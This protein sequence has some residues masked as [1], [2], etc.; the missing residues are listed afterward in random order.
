MASYD[1]GKY[2]IVEWIKERFV[3]G[4][5]CLDVGACDGKWSDLLRDYL[6]MDGIEI[7]QPNIIE[8][9]L[10]D[11]YHRIICGDI[12]DLHYDW[13]DLI[14]FGDVIEHMDVQKAQKVLRYASK[15]CEDMIIGVPWCLSQPAIYGNPWEV[16]IQ[17]DLTEELFRQRYKGY[18]IIIHPLPDYAYWHK[19]GK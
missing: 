18:E 10:R 16:H 15:H 8:H 9:D 17:N 11:K 13:Y 2:E 19:A 6:I 1:A 7:Y 5:S 4:S 3:R 14:I 12:A